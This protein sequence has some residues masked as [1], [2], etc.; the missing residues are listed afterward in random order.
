[1]ERTRAMLKRRPHDI[2]AAQMLIV[3]ALIIVAIFV[4]LNLITL[5]IS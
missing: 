3:P 4:V 1:M 2:S 5:M